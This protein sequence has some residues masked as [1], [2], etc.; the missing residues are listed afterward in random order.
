[1]HG[2]CVARCADYFSAHRLIADRLAHDYFL[3][4][5]LR[6]QYTIFQSYLLKKDYTYTF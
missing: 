3:T 4:S 5:V 6:R 1:M 2:A